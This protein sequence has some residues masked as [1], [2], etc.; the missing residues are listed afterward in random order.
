MTASVPERRPAD[1]AEPRTLPLMSA[2]LRFAL[3][4]MRTGRRF[5][6]SLMFRA[7]RSQIDAAGLERVLDAIARA[8]PALSSRIDFARGTAF[9]Q[10]H[11]FG[12]DVAELHADGSRAVSGL[13]AAAIDEFEA[14][15]GEAPMAARLVRLP[16]EDDLVLLL[17][18][19]AVVD[20]QSLLIIKRQLGDPPAKSPAGFDAE[21]WEHYA[22][23]VRDR[24]AFEEAMS[25]GPGV[26]FWTRRLS[27]V[28]DALPRDRERDFEVSPVHT[29]PGVAVPTGLRGSLFPRVLYSFHRVVREVVDADMTVIAF[30]WGYRNPDFTD[31]VGCFM[32]T[33]L[34]VD[35]T[36]SRRG[37]AALDHFM[38]EWVREIEYADVPY[39]RVLDI[40]SQL[41][42]ARWSGQ[43]SALFTYEHAAADPVIRIAG[44]DCVEITP[45]SSDPGSAVS[46]GVVV[47]DGQLQLRMILDQKVLRRSPDE[48]GARWRAWL[49]EAL[50]PA[51][52]P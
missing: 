41:P 24:V 11:S 12:C 39:S 20:E 2:Q 10:W 15:P 1:G 26:A 43:V 27:A 40:G 4:S 16:D 9:Q 23:A 19:H 52:A 38:S 18:D 33:V 30:A 34:S 50:D 31:V 3:A 48:L 37:P 7:P 22:A 36:G 28:A 42:G 17:F 46:A 32:N 21:R 5:A 25:E 44:V 47:C 51:E 49:R 8:N 35:T 13:V 29:F 6:V 14:G 45:S